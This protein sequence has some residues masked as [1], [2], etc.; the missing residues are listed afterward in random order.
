M[1]LPRKDIYNVFN[2]S[3]IAETRQKLG[4]DTFAVFIDFK[5]AY[6]S[7]QHSLLWQKLENISVPYNV[8]KVLQGLYTNL[9]CCVRV[10]EW[11]TG[12]FNVTQGLRQG[13]I[14]SPT[15]FK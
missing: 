14:L 5:E 8:L 2:L 4:L 10:N 1:A 11:I 6:D 15:L 3:T 12:S 13:C 9:T 7:I